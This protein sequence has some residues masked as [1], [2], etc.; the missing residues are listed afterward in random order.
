MHSGPESLRHTFN[1]AV[2]PHD[3]EDTYLPAFRQLVIDAHSASVMCAYNSIDGDPACAN[4][5]LLTRRLRQDWGFKGYVVSDCAAITDITAGHQ[6]ATDLAHASALAVKAGT[7]L[8]CG[9][10]YAFL[11]DAV[12]DGLISEPEIDAAVKRLFAARFRLGMFDPA[13]I[14]PYNRIPFSENGSPKHAA[15]ALEAARASIV[16]LKNKGAILPLLNTQRRIAVVGPNAAALPALE[17]NYNAV[18]AHPVTPLQALQTRMPG[19]ILYAQGSSYVEGMSVAVPAT[20]FST[21]VNGTTAPGLKAEYFSGNEFAGRPTVMRTDIA[22][23][24]DW[25]GASPAEGVSSGSFSVRWTGSIASP[26][27]GNIRFGFSMAH[28]STCEDEETVRVWLDGKSVYEFDHAPTHG[29]ARTNSFLH[30][31]LQRHASACNSN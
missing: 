16:L 8:S 31:D 24:F 28:C 21:I 14:V 11:T 30:A 7:D 23:D 3:L 15:S 13:D 1:V 17:G 2:S 26:V 5:N 4:N 29:P 6:F 9:K 18:A 19:N 10:E 22:I 20:V 12:H 27:P 25:N